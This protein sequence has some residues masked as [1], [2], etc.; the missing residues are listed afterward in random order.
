[1][2]GVWGGS[3]LDFNRATYENSSWILARGQLF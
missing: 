3:K 2:G 1:M